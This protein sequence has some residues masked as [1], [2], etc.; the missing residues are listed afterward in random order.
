MAPGDEAA[1]ER[2][3]AAIDRELALVEPAVLGLGPRVGDL[4][5]ERARIDR[6]VPGVRRDDGGARARPAGERADGRGL[7]RDRGAARRGLG[8][9]AGEEAA[10]GPHGRDPRRA[11]RPRRLP[12]AVARR[13]AEDGRQG[14]AR[15]GV[16][17]LRARGRLG[18]RPGRPGARGPRP[19]RR[20][21]GRR[22]RGVGPRPAPRRLPLAGRGRGAAAAAR[23]GRSSSW[24]TRPSPR[25]A[26]TATPGPTPQGR[27][28]SHII[29]PRT[30]EPIAHGLASVTVVHRDGAWADAL[31]TGLL[32][33]GPEA[34]RALAAR[35]RL[36]ARL[37][38]RQADGTYAEWSTPAF[39]AL[40][41][42]AR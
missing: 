26:T 1:N 11:A 29:D 21:R 9:R 18:G 36:A 35:E 33:L 7:R 24:R 20:A 40:V 41:V 12:A 8:L 3:R 16:R 34:G 30:G 13:R 6:A 42:P 10:G 5:A 4:A 37:V 2:V 39:E 15:R 22:R 19:R 28:R 25:P 27:R 14:P 17:R 31:A 32:V 23:W 38:L